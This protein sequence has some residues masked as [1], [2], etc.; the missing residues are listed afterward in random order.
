SQR[1]GS[2]VMG[3]RRFFQSVYQEVGGP[4]EAGPLRVLDRVPYDIGM[5][6]EWKAPGFACRRSRSGAR[7]VDAASAA[8]WRV[9]SAM[10]WSIS[11]RTHDH[12]DLTVCLVSVKLTLPSSR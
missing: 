5:K 6:S 2:Q 9:T 11:T 8:A 10:T 12:A 4:A 7:V 1:R 3:P